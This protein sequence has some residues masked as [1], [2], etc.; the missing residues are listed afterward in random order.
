MKFH[1]SASITDFPLI[2]SLE[3]FFRE[4][5]HAGV[6][7]AELVI[8]IKSRFR[9]DYIKELSQQYS[10]PITSIHQPQWTGTPFF[11]EEG[12]IKEAKKLGVTQIV[13]HP[14]ILCSFTNPQMT[15][16]FQRLS[17]LQETYDI[18]VLLENMPFDR[19]YA[20]LFNEKK[21]IH[22]HLGQLLNIVKTYN[23]KITFDT[24]HAGFT[25]PFSQKSFVDLFP[26]IGE[27]HLSSFHNKKDH[28]PLT[29]GNF[30][31]KSFVQELIERNYLGILNLEV[32]YPKLISVIEQ[33]DFSAV[34]A[35]IRVLRELS[36]K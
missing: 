19:A 36:D 20:K 17:T 34:A 30:D 31:S 28:L 9:L 12:F 33:F 18:Q 10:L 1:V 13:F 26:Y 23:F 25:Q 7:S 3:T 8:G 16:Y 11:F 32:Y 35:S 4:F 21:D 24:S 6:D 22:D 27:F 14:L 2:S 15:A 5:R 29:M